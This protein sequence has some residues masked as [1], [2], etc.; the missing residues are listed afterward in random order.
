[1]WK[2]YAIGFAVMAAFMIVAGLALIVITLVN[3]SANGGTP[4]VDWLARA[5]VAVVLG[6]FAATL[7][8]LAWRQYRRAA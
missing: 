8:T 3:P 1:M 5:S 6:G 7:A 4:E 2:I